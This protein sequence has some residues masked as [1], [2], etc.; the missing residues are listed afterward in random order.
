M[1]GV[2][3]HREIDRYTDAHPVVRQSKD[4]FSKGRRRYA[5]IIVD[6]LHDHLLSR[7]WD[8]FSERGRQ[9]FIDDS[10]RILQ[11]NES[12]L[13]ARMRWVAAR[14]IQQDWLGSYRYIENIGRVYDRMSRRLRQPNNLE[15][16]LEEVLVNY[17]ALDGDFQNF[18]PDLRAHADRRRLIMSSGDNDVTL[19]MK[20][21]G[22]S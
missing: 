15:G 16:A 20:S 21:S 9:E 5:G 6:V 12:I 1:Q 18:F 13:P 3:L 22:F 7:Y 2:R 8:R 11:R 4:R 10:Y 14:M 19:S 17:G